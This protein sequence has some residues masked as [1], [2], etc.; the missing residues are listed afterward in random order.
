MEPNNIHIGNIIRTR[1]KEMNL[2]PS[3][4]ARRI[5]YSVPGTTN[6]LNRKAM[7]T[8]VL[9]EICKALDH[10]FFQYYIQA[11]APAKENNNANTENETINKELTATRTE[12]AAIK[13][14]LEYL[15][16]IVA[17]YEERK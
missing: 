3:Q 11:P 10:D 7:Q 9:Q 14:E 1:L 8:D 6:I 12:N 2:T 15:K 13:K 4:L 16:K 5:G 17:L